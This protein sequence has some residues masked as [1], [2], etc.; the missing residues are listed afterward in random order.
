MA[1]V[2]AM[3]RPVTDIVFVCTLDKVPAGYTAVGLFFGGG[4][5]I[6]HSLR[7]TFAS[8]YCFISCKQL[9]L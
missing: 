1:V 6:S 8:A 3:E 4:S 7:H 5:N 2:I 9:K